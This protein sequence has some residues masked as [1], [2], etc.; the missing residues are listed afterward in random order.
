MYSRL[1]KSG[2]RAQTFKVSRFFR[3]LE[4]NTGGSDLSELMINFG[5]PQ[6]PGDEITVKHLSIDYGIFD[7][8]IDENIFFSLYTADPGNPAIDLDSSQS[9]IWQ[10]AVTFRVLDSTGVIQTT[11]HAEV[12]LNEKVSYESPEGDRQAIL[13]GHG[14]SSSAASVL[15][16]GALSMEI[17]LVQRQMPDDFTEFEFDFL[18]EDT[19]EEEENQ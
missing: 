4:I 10:G 8:P 15:S 1:R 19:L 16:M 13:L 7:D 12:E 9:Q 18:R 3:F 11:K 2:E 14:S 5:S 17:T 6:L